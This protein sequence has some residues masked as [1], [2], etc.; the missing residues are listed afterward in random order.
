MSNTTKIITICKNNFI[1]DKNKYYNNLEL[2]KNDIVPYTKVLEVNTEDLMET[3]IN[4]IGLTPE[5][6][7]SSPICHETNTNIYQVIFAGEREQ[8]LGSEQ[9][10]KNENKIAN[11][12]TQDT[13]SGNCV[14]I[15]SKISDI[16]VCV[17]DK[18]DINTLIEILYSKFIHIGINILATDQVNVSEFVYGDHPLEHYH[19]TEYDENK[20]KIIEF[21]FISLGLCAIIDQ[22][23]QTMEN[24]KI[25]KIMTRIIGDQIIYGDVLLILKI[26]TAYEDLNMLL[27]QKINKL[28]F[29]PYNDR[30]LTEDEKKETE[31]VNDLS[32]INNKYC[33]IETR[34]INHNYFTNC[35]NRNCGKINSCK[36][37]LCKGCFRVKYHDKECQM[38][39]WHAHKSECFYEN[40]N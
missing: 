26:S 17:N 36:L 30:K 3:I 20:Y 23:Q 34:L 22:E 10:I 13:I 9:I 18:T 32:V 28:S 2:L 31:K 29:G 27:Y 39:D 24:K 21:E 33:V 4:E 19:I 6:I 14:F 35:A 25:N 1:F 8:N 5:L 40:L 16:N 37:N 11:Y 38:A 15:N 12:L 7:G